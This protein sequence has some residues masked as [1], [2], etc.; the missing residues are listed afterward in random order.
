MQPEPSYLHS[1]PPLA[2]VA[3]WKGASHF[4]VLDGDRI[5]HIEGGDYNDF[6]RSEELFVILPSGRSLQIPNRR[7]GG[8]A[9]E[10]TRLVSEYLE[11]SGVRRFHG[12]MALT[13]APNISEF[14]IDAPNATDIHSAPVNLVAK[15]GSELMGW[16][17]SLNAANA[18]IIH[19]ETD[20]FLRIS[21][22]GDLYGMPL[23]FEIFGQKSAN[24]KISVKINYRPSILST[25]L[26]YLENKTQRGAGT[27]GQ[28]A[29][30]VIK[31]TGQGDASLFFI[32]GMY[33]L[34]FGKPDETADYLKSVS[35]SRAHE[36]HSLNFEIQLLT[37]LL[38]YQNK[39]FNTLKD[40]WRKLEEIRASKLPLA[41]ETLYRCQRLMSNLADQRE[42][43][44]A[45]RWIEDRISWWHLID[46][47]RVLLS[48][49]STNYSTLSQHVTPGTD[50]W[51]EA[52]KKSNLSGSISW[53]N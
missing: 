30:S 12:L 49:R 50:P 53:A 22:V 42:D 33:C 26:K 28:H 21:K 18:N 19:P 32:A 2:I 9:A 17:V 27:L 38:N 29:L 1:V 47:S 4:G 45:K 34:Q 15:S 10:L 43:E 35:A 44:R 14:A 25:F 41:V 48:F 8:N 24:E 16:R 7:S 46:D 23:K 37:V 39:S 3:N 51:S 36:Q 6:F 20:S 52:K 31:D 5:T 40:A 13:S 11:A